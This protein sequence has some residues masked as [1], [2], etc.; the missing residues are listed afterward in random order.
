MAR[1]LLG[2]VPEALP[3][4]VASEVAT[5]TV[6][7]VAMQ[8]SRFWRSINPKATEPFAGAS[9]RWCARD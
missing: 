5:E 4:L 7:Q 9:L 1:I 2:D 3:P 6:W 8:Q